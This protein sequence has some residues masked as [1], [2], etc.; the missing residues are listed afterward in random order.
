MAVAFYM[1]VHVP[2]GVTDQLR[3]RGVEV[4][5]AIEDGRRRQAD[6]RVFERSVELHRVMVTQDK[7][8]RI[9][10]EH[11]Q[12]EGRVFDGLIYAGQAKVSVGRMVSDLELIANASEPGE[13]LN[14]I[15]YLPL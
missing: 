4:L 9:L 11:W 13:W 15:E 6:L 2:Q 5:T 3:R 14:R 1:D 8:F 12:R 7:G 10:A